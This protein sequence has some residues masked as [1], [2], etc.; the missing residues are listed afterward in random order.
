MRGPV[1]ESAPV[2]WGCGCGQGHQPRFALTATRP[3][4]PAPSSSMDAGSGTGEGGGIAAGAATV[5]LPLNDPRFGGLVPVIPFSF[6]VSATLMLSG[7]VPWVVPE[8]VNVPIRY[9]PTVSLP[10]ATEPLVPVIFGEKVFGPTVIDGLPAKL[11]SAD[12]NAKAA[13]PGWVR[14]SDVLLTAVPGGM[15]AKSPLPP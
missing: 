7:S 15:R 6:S 5:K 3:S 9:K 2:G 12:E 10:S 1:A 4:K 11:P 14:V 8:G 13:R